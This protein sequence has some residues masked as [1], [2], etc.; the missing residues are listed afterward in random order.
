MEGE[1]PVMGARGPCGPELPP[2]PPPPPPWNAEARTASSSSDSESVSPRAETEKVLVLPLP[3]EPIAPR[4]TPR[5]ELEVPVG[6]AVEPIEGPNESIDLDPDRL[7]CRIRLFS[8]NPPSSWG[9]TL[10]DTL[11][12]GVDVPPEDMP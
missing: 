12:V 1:G 6:A 5:I 9:S 3:F 7:R 4:T 8:L 11:R 2:A 10:S